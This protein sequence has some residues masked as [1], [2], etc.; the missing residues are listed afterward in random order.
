M[1][2]KSKEKNPSNLSAT[3][4]KVVQVWSV[5]DTKPTLTANIP[6]LAANIA[7]LPKPQTVEDAA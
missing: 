7:S 4:D 1:T 2:M 6:Q 3:L 5:G